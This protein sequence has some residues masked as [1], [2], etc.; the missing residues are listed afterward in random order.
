[1]NASRSVSAT[2]V[3]R[4]GGGRPRRKLVGAAPGDGGR[5]RPP[6]VIWKTIFWP[7]VGLTG[8]SMVRLAAMVTRKS[9]PSEASTAMA[10]ASVRATTAGATAP[11]S[12]VV[13][14]LAGDASAS[15]RTVPPAAPTAASPT[16]RLRT[17]RRLTA[18]SGS[19][20]AISSSSTPASLELDVRRR[21][22]ECLFMVS[23]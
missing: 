7:S 15:A 18:T 5:P 8:F 16:A 14:P 2:V 3:L 21:V 23:P 13:W 1:M 10:E 22:K 19:P 12:V 11:C 17:P 6:W 20:G 4:M 9:F